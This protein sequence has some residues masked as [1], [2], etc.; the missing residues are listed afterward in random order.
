V[1]FTGSEP[2]ENVASTA[3]RPLPADAQVRDKLREAVARLDKAESCGTP[4]DLIDALLP[5]SRCYLSIGAHNA[6]EETLRQALRAARRSGSTQK[7]ADVLTEL[8]QVASLHGLDLKDHDPSAARVSRDRA[9][10]CAF[11]ASALIHKHAQAAWA[12]PALLAVAEVLLL[13]GDQDDAA[14]MRLRA[15][16]W[17]GKC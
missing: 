5:V 9:R 10:D 6:A 1:Q 13:C 2:I 3:T 16:S 11:E 15:Q 12:A 8:A 7:L 14:A 4:E 17:L